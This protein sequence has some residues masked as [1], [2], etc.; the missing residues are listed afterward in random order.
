MTVVD[1]S[2]AAIITFLFYHAKPWPST[3][4]TCKTDSATLSGWKV[5]F[6]LPCNHDAEQPGV[7]CTRKIPWNWVVALCSSFVEKH[8]HISNIWNHL[9]LNDL[10]QIDWQLKI[11]GW[12]ML[13]LLNVLNQT[14]IPR[15]MPFKS[16]EPFKYLEPQSNIKN[17]QFIGQKSHMFF[18]RG[19]E[20]PSNKYTGSWLIT[21][22]F[23]FNKKHPIFG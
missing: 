3:H 7:D 1:A 9:D 10:V 20:F 11:H 21:Y 2:Y 19:Q 8:F 16:F 4:K 14:C 12:N 15:K 22:L 23:K 13:K 6:R 17:Q 5:T 18:L